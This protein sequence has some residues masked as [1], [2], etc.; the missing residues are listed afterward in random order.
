MQHK[1]TQKKKHFTCRGYNTFEGI[2]KVGPFFVEW[3]MYENQT[4]YIGHPVYVW[5]NIG[6][7]ILHISVSETVYIF[8][9]KILNMGHMG[10]KYQI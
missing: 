8:V 4:K 6:I 1:Q 5:K 7:S 10:K 9:N 2:I 3:T